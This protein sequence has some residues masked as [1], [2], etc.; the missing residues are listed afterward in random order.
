[1]EYNF[2]EIIDRHNTGALKYDALKPRWGRDDLLPLWVADMDFR[3]PPV[4]MEALRK[5]CEHDI[6]GYTMKPDRYYQAIIDWQQHRFGWRVNRDEIDFTSGIVPGLAFAVSCFTDPGDRVLIQPPVYHPFAWVTRRNGRKIINNPLILENGQYRMDLRGFQKAVKGCK[7]FILCN[8]H[9]P[10]GRVWS[11]QELEAIADICHENGTL[12]LSDEIHA[13]LTQPGHQHIPFATVSEKARTNAITFMAASKAFNMPG[14]SSSYNIIKNPVVRRRFVR[15][16][17]ASE[18]NQGHL[19]AYDPVTAAY[20]PQGEEWLNQMLRYVQRN[21]DFV[22]TFLQE[23]MP[24][25]KAIRPEASYLIFLDCRQLH[26]SQPELV[27]LFVDGARLA[28]NDGAMFGKEG[29]GFMRLN[30][31]CPQS[32]LKQ[33]LIRLQTAYHTLPHIQ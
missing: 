16:L 32:I 8:P 30:A 3:T 4:V 1:M 6:L 26:L 15:F 17:E 5:R 10:G 24:R 28:L 2:D 21:I 20:S 22:D 19:F 25:I 12:V 31:G 27:N 33:A 13:D 29:I 7:L 9:N 23:N 11:R 14:L 18:L